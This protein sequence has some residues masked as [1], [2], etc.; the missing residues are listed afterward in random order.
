[1]LARPFQK[2]LEGSAPENP[3]A[4]MVFLVLG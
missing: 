1:V 4:I 2:S 3:V